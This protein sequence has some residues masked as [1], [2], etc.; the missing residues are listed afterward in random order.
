MKLW[1]N[2]LEL[3]EKLS[4]T[5]GGMPEG[6]LDY[7]S[8]NFS[9]ASRSTEEILGNLLKEFLRKLSRHSHS[10]WKSIPVEFLG[11]LWKIF[12]KSITSENS[13]RDVQKTE[14]LWPLQ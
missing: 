3:Q 1:I 10:N 11:N 4:G 5:S 8:G 6:L 7:F 12:R 14:H 9:M 2:S 13:V